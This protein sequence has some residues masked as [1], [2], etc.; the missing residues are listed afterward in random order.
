MCETREGGGGGGELDGV[1]RMEPK[2][3]KVIFLAESEVGVLKGRGQCMCGP[4]SDYH[5]QTH[6]RFRC[7]HVHA[8]A[9]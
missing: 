2:G 9:A 4:G 6:A 8:K 7:P 5:Q 3:W 1:Q